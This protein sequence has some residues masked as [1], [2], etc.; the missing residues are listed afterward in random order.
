MVREKFKQILW[1]ICFDGRT[2]RSK[3][4]KT[5]RFGLVS[6]IWNK[7]IENSQVCCKP[8][9][10]ITVDEQLF[11]LKARCWFM[12]YTPNKPNNFG[13]KD[14]SNKYV[15]NGFPYLRKDQKRASSVL[16]SEYVV[17]KLVQ[18]YI[19]CGRNTTTTVSLGCRCQQNY[20]LKKKH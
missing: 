20:W 10:N 12:Q 3:R 16:S 4:L 15:S 8:E 13:I 5:D 2:E 1:F 11:P 19:E 17:M 14:V 18:P 9:Q 7:F 6:E